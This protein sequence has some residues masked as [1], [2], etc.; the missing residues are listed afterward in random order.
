MTSLP[1]IASATL[2][3]YDMLPQGAIVVVMLSGGA[4]SV[5]LLLVLAAMAP[6]AGLKLSALHVNHQLRAGASDEDE[7]FV[8]EL[9]ASLRI[10]LRVER[11]AVGK[12][13]EQEGLNLEDAGRRVRYELASEEIDA[14]CAAA[15]EPADMGRI[16]VAHTRDDRTET[17][18][19]RLAQGAG[20]TGL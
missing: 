11:V 5:S 10:P 20:A 2:N 1:D 15:G 16:A 13:A 17:F 19:M 6:R 3:R 9:C 8:H 14:R 12:L 18:M 7:S 4:D